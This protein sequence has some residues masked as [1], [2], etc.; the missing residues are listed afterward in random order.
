[1]TGSKYAINMDQLED[2]G[3]LHMEAHMFFMKMQEEQPDII[4]AIMTQLLLK[5]GL[6]QWGEKPTT[7]CIPR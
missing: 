6:K 7:L 4:A 3:A 1:M 2:N 5:A